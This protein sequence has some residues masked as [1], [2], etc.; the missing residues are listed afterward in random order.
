[1]LKKLA[2]PLLAV[3]ILLAGLAVWKLSPSGEATPATPQ[4]GDFTL[5]SADGDVSLHDFRG[6]VVLLYFGYTFCPDVCPTSLAMIAQAMQR[7]T[8]EEQSQVRILFISVDP[9]R[10]T[11]QKLKEYGNFFYPGIVGMT[12][13]PKEIARTAKMYGVVYRRQDIASA[14]G[15]VIDHSSYTYLIGRDG[16]LKD[17]LLHASAPADMAR[18]I[19]VLLKN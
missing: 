11:P 13:T 17:K 12:G 9:E 2:V 1:M 7:L 8:P 15:Y 6:K 10:D 19:R 18:S 14:G 16:M 5:H 4:G 3:L